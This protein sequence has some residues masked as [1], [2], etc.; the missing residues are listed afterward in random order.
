MEGVPLKANK[1]VILCEPPQIY[2]K[3]SQC[4]CTDSDRPSLLLC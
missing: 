3:Q 1:N 2:Y 4:V